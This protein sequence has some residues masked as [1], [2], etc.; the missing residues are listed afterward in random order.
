MLNALILIFL[1]AHT[2]MFVEEHPLCPAMPLSVFSM[3]LVLQLC[4]IILTGSYTEKYLY[5]F[6]RP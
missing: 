3:G 4:V 1:K 2:C 6:Q 5:T